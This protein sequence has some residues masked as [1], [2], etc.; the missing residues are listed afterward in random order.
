VSSKPFGLIESAKN[1]LKVFTFVVA[2]ADF[3]RKLIQSIRVFPIA[4]ALMLVIA[5]L[6]G[7]F[8]DRTDPY[9][10]RDTVVL[11]LKVFIAII[12]TTF[13]I[14]FIL[15]DWLKKSEGKR[16]TAA[17]SK[18]AFTDPFNLPSQIMHGYKLAFITGRPPTFTGLTGDRY[19]ADDLA[20]CTLN[21]EHIPPVMDCDCGFYAFKELR[22]AQFELSINPGAFL[23][24]VDLFGVGFEYG[25]GFKAE[26]QLVN[27]LKIPNRCMRCKIFAPIRFVTTYKMGFNSFAYWKWEVRCRMCSATFK[28]E[29]TVEF[30]KMN[31]HLGISARI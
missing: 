1:A 29:D 17:Q 20:T 11:I 21:P 27:S 10:A 6:F 8:S 15:A 2:S 4:T 23:I 5:Y 24:D 3:E 18:F 7:G 30:S 25:R 31:K 28:E 9:I 26:S 16:I 14:F 22:D 13:V 12:P 19:S